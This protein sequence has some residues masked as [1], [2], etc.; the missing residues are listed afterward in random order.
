V[1]SAAE[2]PLALDRQRDEH[3]PH[4]RKRRAYPSH[5]WRLGAV[6]SAVTAALPTVTAGA[7][8]CDADQLVRH[9][10]GG[11]RDQLM[12]GHRG[13]VDDAARLPGDRLLE[14]VAYEA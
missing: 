1:A 12:I 8:A 4:R 6:Q 2:G 14:H 10:G 9:V 7:G 11:E 3:Q 5:G 13:Q